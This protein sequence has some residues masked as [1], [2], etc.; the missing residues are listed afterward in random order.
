MTAAG[1]STWR[2]IRS[3]PA[4]RAVSRARHRAP[5]ATW[6]RRWP[7]HDG[8]PLVVLVAP[9]GFGKTTLLHEWARSRPAPVRVAHAGR[10]ATTIR[11]C[12]CGRCR[13]PSTRPR[14][15][16]GRAHRARARRRP[17]AALGR[18]RR[19]TIAAIA[20]HLPDEITVALASRTELPLPV[21]RLRAEGLVTELRHG[22]LAMTRAE[23]ADAAAARRPARST[24]DD[25]D[26]LLRSTEGWPAGLSLAALSLGRPARRRASAVARFGGRDRL[27]AEYLR[28]E[29]L[30]PLAPDERRFVLRDL[31]PGR[32]DRGRVRRG[33]RTPRLGRRR[34]RGCCAR[35]S[36]SWRSTARP[37]AT[38]TIACSA[39]CCAPSCA[40]T[41]PELERRAAPARQRLARQRG[42][43]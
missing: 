37:S 6:W 39:T 31:D 14:R 5:A 15:R 36:R 35:A 4:A 12:C 23:A 10:G 21:A 7:H 38:A 11:G 34:S 29:V 24:A 17:R 42:R 33:A 25:V 32:A 28:D 26:A 9:A 3:P 30:A 22:E 1:S 16:A 43:S 20:T 8:P 27:V 2:T 19:D 40:A 41:E 13:E 18:A